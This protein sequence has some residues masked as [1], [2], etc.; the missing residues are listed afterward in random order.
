M[1]WWEDMERRRVRNANGYSS[2]AFRPCGWD[3]DSRERLELN[4]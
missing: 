2:Q 4:N 1:I 3:E